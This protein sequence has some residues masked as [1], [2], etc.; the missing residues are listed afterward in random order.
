MLIREISRIGRD[1]LGGRFLELNPKLFE[2]RSQLPE[3]GEISNRLCRISADFQLLEAMIDEVE[4][5]L[6][7]IHSLANLKLHNRFAI[8]EEIE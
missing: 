8:E 5:D 6:L 3:I 2:P 4:L 7:N 1:T